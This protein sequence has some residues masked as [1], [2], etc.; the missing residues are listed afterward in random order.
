MSQD[1]FIEGKT[2]SYFCKVNLFFCISGHL[3]FDRVLVEVVSPLNE[4]VHVLH[5]ICIG[6][7][8]TGFQ[9]LKVWPAWLF[10]II[11]IA[12]FLC[13]IL[14]GWRVGLAW[15]ACPFRYEWCGRKQ[16][17]EGLS[18]LVWHSRE[19]TVT[20]NSYVNDSIPNLLWQTLFDKTYHA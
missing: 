16:F 7:V 19:D 15:S 18:V 11:K 1:R 17:V 5:I 3:D 13:N 4:C 6:R 14:P 10:C 2:G 9:I 8:E 12:F 20:T